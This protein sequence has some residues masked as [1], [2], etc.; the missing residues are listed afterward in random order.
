MPLM[1]VAFSVVGYWPRFV[2]NC[3]SCTFSTTPSI[4]LCNIKSNSGINGASRKCPSDVHCP[5]SRIVRDS[6]RPLCGDP[7]VMNSELRSASRIMNIDLYDTFI[8]YSHKVDSGLVRV[9]QVSQGRWVRPWFSAS[10]A[11]LSRDHISLTTTPHLRTRIV[12]SWR[13]AKSAPR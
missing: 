12:R 13:K 11:K 1:L 5:H 3:T 2:G 4:D 8:S 6:L 10:T 9:L 7:E